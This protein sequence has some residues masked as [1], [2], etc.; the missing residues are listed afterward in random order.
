[1]QTEIWYYRDFG[2]RPV[3]RKGR[4]VRKYFPS[5][6]AHIHLG[7]LVQAGKDGQIATTSEAHM[8][9]FK[10]VFL[11]YVSHIQVYYLHIKPIPLTELVA[12][13]L[14]LNYMGFSRA[15]LLFGKGTIIIWSNKAD[16]HRNTSRRSSV[17]RWQYALGS[18]FLCLGDSEFHWRDLLSRAK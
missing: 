4:G 6:E 18:V 11:Q 17:L 1:M 8:H 10:A 13:R 3:S 5:E 14:F 12:S 15:V 9:Y 2:L 16:S 7:K